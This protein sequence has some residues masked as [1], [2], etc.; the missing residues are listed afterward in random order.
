[1]SYVYKLRNLDCENLLRIFFVLGLII[2]VLPLLSGC[3]TSASDLN[4][5]MAALSKNITSLV[6]LI[7]AVSYIMGLW[8]IYS[9]LYALKLYGDARTMMASQGAGMGGPLFRMILGVFLL[10]FPGMVH[11]MVNSLW[12]AGTGAPASITDYPILS[13]EMMPWSDTMHGVIDIIRVLGYISVLRGFY[14]LSKAAHQGSQPGMY[15]KG[16]LHIAAGIMA[17][18][19]VGTINVIQHSFGLA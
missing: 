15:G 14:T 19:V 7:A 17:I 12:A 8:M 3:T 4:K 11:I 18:N 10:L 1:M 6:K 16:T 2:L 5:I 13:S 9:A